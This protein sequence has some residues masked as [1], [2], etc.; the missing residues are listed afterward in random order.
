MAGIGA[1]INLS[2]SIVSEKLLVGEFAKRF[3]TPRD[4]SMIPIKEVLAARFNLSE[5]VQF[6]RK[7]KL[8]LPQT[9]QFAGFG[10]RVRGATNKLFSN[11]GARIRNLLLVLSFPGNPMA[12]GSTLDWLRQIG[13]YRLVKIRM[14]STLQSIRDTEYALLYERYRQL[15]KVTNLLFLK[16][17]REFMAAPKGFS[18]GLLNVL[19]LQSTIFPR[20]DEAPILKDALTRK[21]RPMIKLFQKP[22]KVADQELLDPRDRVL[23][24]RARSLAALQT[25]LAAMKSYQLDKTLLLKLEE[26]KSK[27]DSIQI[28]LELETREDEPVRRP[29]PSKLLRYRKHIQ[30]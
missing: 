21:G 6:V 28:A 5:L 19:P 27:L 16:L 4:C 15:E 23:V 7:Y 17:H 30:R 26:F 3:Y 8:S 20:I 11:S 13:L 29:R 25:E 12:R 14:P 2:K 18:A 24:E 10:Y 9:L 22:P 1:G